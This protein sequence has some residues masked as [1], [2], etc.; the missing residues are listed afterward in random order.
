MGRDHTAP[1]KGLHP[2][3]RSDRAAFQRL[4]ITASAEHSLPRLTTLVFLVGRQRAQCCPFIGL[5]RPKAVV[6]EGLR[7]MDTGPWPEF[8]QGFEL[9][10]KPVHGPVFKAGQVGGR[11]PDDQAILAP[12]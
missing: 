6:F 12:G 7:G 4:D 11:E 3:L 10:E 1:N 8:Q 2:V 5:L 9:E